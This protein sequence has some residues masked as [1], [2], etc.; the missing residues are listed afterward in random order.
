MIQ[1]RQ[2]PPAHA[3]TV[4]DPSHERWIVAVVTL[5]IF[6]TV[7][8]T[9]MVNVALPAIG[10]HFDAGEARLGWLVTAY[11]LTFG[12]G[13]PF[14]GRLGDRY[15][16]RAVFVI[17]LTIF[18]IASILA[19]IAVSFPM[20]LVF[21]AL[22]AAGAASIPSLGIAMIARAIPQER[23]GR[24]LGVIST[25]VGAG[26]AIGPTLGGAATE[27]VSWRMV[28]L[29][30]AALGA[31]IPL[32]LRYLPES[33]GEDTGRVDWL[34]GITLGA[35][36][37]GLLLAVAGL[38]REGAT[39]ILVIASI[40]VA[41]VGMALTFWRQRMAENP[42]IERVLLGN[43]RYLLLTLIG[44]LSMTGNIGALVVAPFLFSTINGLSSGQI[45]LAL[46]PQALAVAF[47]SRTAGRLSDRMDTFTLVTA[48][49]LINFA[50]LLVMATIGIGWPAP[51]FAALA[52]F[53][54]IGQALVNA[55]LST[56]LTATVP[57]R[58][59][60]AGLGIYN[61]L[62]FVGSGFGAA[63]STAI[64]E[65]R[66]DAGSAILPVYLGSE[67]F[68]EFSDA[69]LPGIAAFAL[70]AVIAQVARRS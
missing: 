70:A 55:P 39:S 41:V 54:G 53:L 68:I 20:L 45:G 33:R 22:Q 24:T 31:L 42:F 18:V 14:Y 29:L 40:L 63:I 43:R 37:A 66:E 62:F 3:T 23:R 35:A 61:M 6:L 17:G 52:I 27:I 69:F 47:L 65:A 25:A 36:I 30:S 58:V 49:L 56:T 2:R 1:T 60:G 13:T 8:N 5:A 50:T 34:G 19:G 32:S 15:G 38:Q 11:S 16:R 12:V 21:R 64:V 9:S 59:Y 48:G 28:F 67:R 46:L 7:A 51:A 4:D 57:A 44:F 10:D 26:S